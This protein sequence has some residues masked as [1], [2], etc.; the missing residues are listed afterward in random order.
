MF[1]V[2]RDVRFLTELLIHNIDSGDCWWSQS[3]TNVFHVLIALDVE[4]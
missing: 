1:D 3:K 2:K 4:R